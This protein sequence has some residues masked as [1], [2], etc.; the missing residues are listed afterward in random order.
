M[1]RDNFCRGIFNEAQNYNHPEKSEKGNADQ[2][3][4]DEKAELS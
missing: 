1:M 3:C 2:S 4:T